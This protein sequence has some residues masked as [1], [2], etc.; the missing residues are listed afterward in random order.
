MRE[1]KG[2]K[3]NG[4]ERKEKEKKEREGVKFKLKL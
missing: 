1:K 2:K 3:G 4:I